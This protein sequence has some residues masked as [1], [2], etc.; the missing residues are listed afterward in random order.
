M[1]TTSD[2]ST[3]MMPLNISLHVFRCAELEKKERVLVFF[4]SKPEGITCILVE[5]AAA[6]L[7]WTETLI[8]HGQNACAILSGNISQDALAYIE[9]VD[10]GIIVFPMGMHVTLR[11]G[12]SSFWILSFPSNLSAFPY[13]LPSIRDVEE[14]EEKNVTILY[15]P[16]EIAERQG[17][18]SLSPD[19][20]FRHIRLLRSKEALRMRFPKDA[21]LGRFL[22]GAMLL[23]EEE[24]R[25]RGRIAPCRYALDIEAVQRRTGALH[26]QI[27]RWIM[28][29]QEEGW[30]EVM[31]E[32]DHMRRVRKSAYE[33]LQ[34]TVQW[35]ENTD[36]CRWKLF[37]AITGR[38][39]YEKQCG[40]CDI[41]REQVRRYLQNR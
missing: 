15:S 32:N 21:E 28:Y 27:N 14:D 39:L 1:M 20:R 37:S 7:E 36:E 5:D 33:E 6:A 9:T 35:L 22:D 31:S 13:L 2:K 10:S 24:Q 40:K 8:H 25:H 17:A 18:I 12:W 16:E 23:E 41:C 26:D 11:R 4:S 19:G 3:A 34:K 29:L 38:R 30:I